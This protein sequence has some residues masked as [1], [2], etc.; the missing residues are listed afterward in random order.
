MPLHD[1]YYC[2]TDVTY[3]NKDNT[4]RYDVNFKELQYRPVLIICTYFSMS[5]I[6]NR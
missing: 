6:Y 2:T 5:V 4:A 3:T 1:I